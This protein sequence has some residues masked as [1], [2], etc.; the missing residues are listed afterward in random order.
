MMLSFNLFGAV[1]IMGTANPSGSGIEK[2]IAM[3]KDGCAYTW[4][5]ILKQGT[6]KFVT[7]KSSDSPCYTATDANKS[8]TLNAP[9]A[10]SYSTSATSNVFSFESGEYTLSLDTVNKM[11]TVIGTKGQQTVIGDNLFLIGPSTAAG[12]NAGQAILM[13]KNENVYTYTGSFEADE[14]KFLCRQGSWAPCYVATA[15]NQ[16]VKAGD[17]YNLAYRGTVDSTTPDY[18]FIMPAGVFT[19]TV[20]IDE[21]NHTGKL[22]VSGSSG[23]T[24]NPGPTPDPD[25]T[26]DVK[27]TGLQIV[28]DFSSPLWTPIAMEDLGSGIFSYTDNFE[29]GKVFK[30]RWEEDWWPGLTAGTNGNKALNAGD[31][32]QMTYYE[33]QP[34]DAKDTKWY[35]TTSGTQTIYVDLNNLIIS[36]TIPTE[37]YDAEGDSLDVYSQGNFIYVQGAQ[38][39]SEYRLMNTIKVIK[40][41]IVDSDRIAIDVLSKGIYFLSIGEKTVK[42]LVNY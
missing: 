37:V 23:P 12:W 29:A 27:L 14:L 31:S 4:Y 8:V 25:P 30:F 21:N 7:S 5:G 11:L 26:P 15:N 13:E 18:K 20:T 24:P 34:S 9:M 16:S 10:V 38:L 33:N 22:V 40:S 17:T 1:Y 3:Q 39:G 2:S 32:M 35:F 36:T 28:G 41:G 6:V 42:I 19:L